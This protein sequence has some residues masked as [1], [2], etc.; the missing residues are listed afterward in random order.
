MQLIVPLDAGT[1]FPLYKQLADGILKSIEDGK[2]RP[3]QQLPSTRE[4]AETMS[5]SKLTAR[6]CYEVLS[7]QGYIKTF[8]R[9]KTIVSDSFGASPVAAPAAIEPR[10]VKLSSYGKRLLA[11]RSNKSVGAVAR[12]HEAEA[13]YADMPISKYVDCLQ[14]AVRS[15]KQSLQKRQTDSFGLLELRQQICALVARSRG[16]NCSPEQIVIFPSVEGGLD[17]LC[18]IV[19]DK[20]DT[21]ALEEPCSPWVKASCAF[22]HTEIRHVPLDAEGINMEILKSLN[23]APAMVYVTPSHQDTTGISMTKLRR[24][25]LLQWAAS[26]ECLILEDDFDSEFTCG[27][28]PQPALFAQGTPGTVI[29][30]SNFWKSLY[31]MVKLSFLIIP[32]SLIAVFR[33]IL[34]SERT[35]IPEVEQYALAN[36]IKK[37]HYERY[38]QKCRKVLVIKRAS[39]IHQFT[40]HMFGKVSIPKQSSATQLLVRF[41]KSLTS[42]Q[43]IDASIASGLEIYSTA[44]NYNLCDA[45][46]NEFLV[47]FNRLEE[48]EVERKVI[49]FAR[50]CSRSSLS[51]LRV[52]LTSPLPSI[53]M[54]AFRTV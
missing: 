22:E 25:R 16:I 45:P 49:E 53:Q 48:S 6:R 21:V 30:R 7:S 39:V 19:I 40:R 36:F 47:V 15:F 8:S 11:R 20:G 9:G 37:G 54:D 33:S 51:E 43:I 2:L 32:S 42:E 38:L 14:D 3:G 52:E 23:P 35:D 26:N 12:S 34:D 24:H 41:D 31:P 1:G 29:F 28:S 18:R 10:P 44:Q 17:L 46:E 4:L 27:E 13:D 5:V 50:V